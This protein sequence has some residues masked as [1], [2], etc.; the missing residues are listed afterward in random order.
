M[1]KM[2]SIIL[3]IAILLTLLPQVALT[4]SA[5]VYSGT[6]GDNLIWSFDSDTG[7]LSISGSGEMQNYSS[8]NPAPWSEYKS[9]IQTVSFENGITTIGSYAFSGIQLDTIIIPEGVT[10]ISSYAFSG[11]PRVVHLPS[12]LTSVGS[13]AMNGASEAVYIPSAKDWIEIQWSGSMDWGN[14]YCTSNP[15]RSGATLYINNVPVSEFVIP[16]GTTTIPQFA[17]YGCRTITSISIPSTVTNIGGRAFLN[18]KNLKRIDISD[19]L[20]FCNITLQTNSNGWSSND[21]GEGAAPLQNGADLYLN[22]QIL[23]QLYVPESVTSISPYLFSGCTSIVDVFFPSSPI[24]VGSYAFKNCPNLK[25]TIIPAYME[26]IP[27]GL[28]ANCPALTDI[29]IPEGVTSIGAYAFSSC[30]IKTVSLPSTLTSVGSEAMNGASEAVYIP[31]AKDWIEIQW[32]G[33]MDWGNYYCTSNPLRSGATLYINNVPVS[34]FVIP[35]GTTTIPQFAFYGCRTITSI[36]IPSTVTNIGGRAFL[37]CKNLKRIDISDFLAFCNITLQTNSNG[38]SSNDG[39]KGAAP[40]QNG[41]DLYLNNQLVTTVDFS[42]DCSRISNYLFNGCKSIETVVFWGNIQNIGTGAFSDCS[43]LNSAYFTG[44]APPVSSSMFSNCA[45]D[46]VIYYIEGR[47]GWTSPTWNGYPTATWDGNPKTV[48]VGNIAN[49]ATNELGIVVYQNKKTSTSD[50]DDYELCEGS[51]IAYD[52]TQATTDKNGQA[53]IP[54]P[55]ENTVT[56]YAPGCIA[57][58]IP[59]STLQRNG[60]VNLQKENPDAPVIS[61]VWVGISSVDIDVLNEEHKVDL[62]Q[63]PNEEVIV[64][65]IWAGAKD[66]LY[67]RQNEKTVELNEFGTVIDWNTFDVS[68]SIEIVAKDTNGVQIS[69]KLNVSAATASVPEVFDGFSF[70][71][72]QKLSFTLPDSAG[73]LAGTKIGTGLY[74]NIPV[75]FEVENGK[76]YIAIG[77]ENGAS[78]KNGKKTVKDFSNSVKEL[79]KTL[80]KSAKEQYNDIVKNW[81]KKNP[82][83][84]GKGSLGFDADF[85]VMGF[86]EGYIH[87]DGSVELI[88]AGTVSYTHLTL[89]TKA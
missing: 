13:E 49:A 37:N 46:F 25:N 9:L 19:F 84:G 30:G 80:E 43:N 5:V 53:T 10:S 76:I 70:G 8:S 1:K 51:V 60:R 89:P 82:F 78:W 41:A 26:T 72:G 56:V 74:S 73:L 55:S 31:S 69:R 11:T 71:M 2:T 12:T 85:S 75:S 23:T 67:L 38:W 33:S 20:A 29:V 39:G 32:S 40:L 45:S 66:K 35:E 87:P 7:N 14:Y 79:R 42:S 88:D 4:A 47:T 57:R 28:F 21:G 27:N 81:K 86:G 61:G 22:G 18:C 62:T 15:L 3:A 63:A 6:C 50:K 68:Q 59:V 34:E 64:E 52:G 36:S 83:T 48:H 44:D 77:Y 16:E 58:T 54:V 17:F 24:N 65:I